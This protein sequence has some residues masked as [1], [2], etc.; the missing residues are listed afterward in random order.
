MKKTK[1][2]TGLLL[3]AFVLLAVCAACG[4]KPTGGE[5]SQPLVHRDFVE[6]LQLDMNSETAKEEVTIKCFVD[7]D[8]THFYVPKTVS[9]NGVFKA[10][11]LA[12]NTPECTGKVEEYGKTAAQFTKSKLENAVSI[13]IESDNEDWNIDSTASRNLAWVWYKPSKDAPYRNLN[14][15]I[16]QNGLAIASSAAQNR[17]GE[18]CVAAIAQ[19]KAEKLGVYSGEP[20]PNF[21]YG[22]SI[23]LTLKELR[24]NISNYEGMKVA[25]NGVITR[26]SGNTAYIEDYDAENNI[27][28]GMAL[29]YGYG[30]PGEGLDV[31][32]V[33]NYVRIVGTVQYYETG[34]TYQVSG[35]TYKVMRPNDPDNIQVIES[36]H[37]A[38]FLKVDSELF[39]KG[40]VEVEFE[41]EVQTHKYAELAM[42]ST[43]SMDGLTIQSIYT[44]NDD[45]SSSYGAMTMTCKTASGDK[46]T[47]RTVPFYNADGT[48]VEQSFYEGH[49]INVRGLV[50]YFSGNYQI[51]VLN[52]ADIEI[53]K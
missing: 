32:S 10:R 4:K 12:I 45:E 53:V 2:L 46:I 7:G 28:Y 13:I 50:D 44:T 41:E 49:T 24:C 43:I 11:Y 30:L 34:G 37:Q 25:F 29:Y 9:E 19:A 21:Y 14:L 3:L 8:T 31:L 26:H 27:L 22:D 52:P 38:M 35:M 42:N 51:K 5:E 20:D 40:T 39:A 36:G 23:E 15:E 16:L 33:G 18:Y 48:L 6:E 17:Y 47:V 1:L